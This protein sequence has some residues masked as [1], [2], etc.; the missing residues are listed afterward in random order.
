ML[1]SRSYLA[2][3]SSR[4]HTRKLIRVE[5][6]SRWHP[7]RQSHHPRTPRYQSMGVT[8]IAS[9]DPPPTLCFL[10]ADDIFDL[11]LRCT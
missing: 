4:N 9:A 8:D 3:P 1:W 2:S 5:T 7:Q 10:W 11:G 6:D